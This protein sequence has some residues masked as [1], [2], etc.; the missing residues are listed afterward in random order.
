VKLRGQHRALPGTTTTQ[1]PAHEVPTRGRPVPAPAYVVIERGRRDGCGEGRGRWVIV[2]ETV[3][4]TARASIALWQGLRTP[5]Q[6]ASVH[7]RVIA[8]TVGPGHL[9]RH[10][11]RRKP[12]GEKHVG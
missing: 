9:T 5:A 7:M 10:Y 11:R 6:Q 4:A 8:V 3:G 2:V 12:P 1:P